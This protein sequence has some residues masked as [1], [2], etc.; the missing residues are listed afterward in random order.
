[1]SALESSFSCISIVG[2]VLLAAAV[3]VLPSPRCSYLRIYWWIFLLV[4]CRTC[5]RSTCALRSRSCDIGV[6]N[7][8]HTVRGRYHQNWHPHTRRAS[9]GFSPKIRRNAA[10]CRAIAEK[11]PLLSIFVFLAKR[12]GASPLFFRSP[13]FPDKKKNHI[14]PC[15]NEYPRRKKASERSKKKT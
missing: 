13:P 8:V 10:F 12:V 4:G 9:E 6:A 7:E 1:M 11:Q 2:S 5:S 15:R 3:A 14:T